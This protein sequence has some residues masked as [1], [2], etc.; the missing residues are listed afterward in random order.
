MYMYIYLLFLGCVFSTKADFKIL[1]NLTHNVR[2][3]E[4]VCVCMCVYVC[5]CVRVCVCVCFVR[6]RRNKIQPLCQTMSG[7]NPT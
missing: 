3:H 1:I 5:V 6:L 4:C 7:A 2:V